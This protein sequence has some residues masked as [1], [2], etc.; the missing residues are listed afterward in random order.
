MRKLLMGAAFSLAIAAP[1]F[2]QN[3]TS[4]TQ[5]PPSPNA[6]SGTVEPTNSLPPGAGTPEGTQPGSAVGTAPPSPGSVT[7]PSN[8]AGTVPLTPPPASR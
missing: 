8:S 3:S 2:A 7:A 5:N 1:A 4:A 6:S